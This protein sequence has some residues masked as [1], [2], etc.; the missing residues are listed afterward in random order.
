MYISI[1]FTSQITKHR[2]SLVPQTKIR[3]LLLLK[4]AHLIYYVP[5]TKIRLLLLLLKVAHLIY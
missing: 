3:L 5:Q 2:G 4:V 1:D